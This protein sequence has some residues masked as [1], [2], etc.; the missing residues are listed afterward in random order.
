MVWFGSPGKDG[1]VNVGP[2]V[3]LSGLA[4]VELMGMAWIGRSGIGSLGTDRPV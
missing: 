2:G 1:L 3:A 4:V